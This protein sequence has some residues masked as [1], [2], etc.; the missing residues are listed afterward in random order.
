MH[1][2]VFVIYV[3]DSKIVLLYGDIAI[4]FR[5]K[6][7]VLFILCYKAEKIDLSYDLVYQLI[8]AYI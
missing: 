7:F 4:S 1:K 2:L 8:T 3:L 6:K 5:H